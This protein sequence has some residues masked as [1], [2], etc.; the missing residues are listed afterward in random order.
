MSI[1]LDRINTLHDSMRIGTVK[2][3]RVQLFQPEF[4]T[5][6]LRVDALIKED[7]SSSR[8]GWKSSL[9]DATNSSAK[10]R[11]SFVPDMEARQ[12]LRSF[13]DEGRNF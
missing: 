3:W 2:E 9:C 4:T 1:R 13:V 7:T 10:N 12:D 8:K 6:L 5:I 11:R